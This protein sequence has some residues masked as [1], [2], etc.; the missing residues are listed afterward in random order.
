M[1]L[2]WFTIPALAYLLLQCWQEIV[3]LK[4]RH[5]PRILSEELPP[6]SIWIAARNEETNIANCLQSLVNLDY[7][8]DRMQILVGNDESKDSTREI[9]KSFEEEYN[10]ITVVDIEPDFS[11]SKA[12]VMAKLDKLA[13]GDYYLITDAD[14]CVNPN[15][16][17]HLIASMGNETGVC[18]GTTM[19]KGKGW[20]YKMQEIDWT[21]FMGLL[22]VIS[23]SG[24][25]ATAVGNNMIVRA[26]AYWETGGYSAIRFS[27]TED[28]KLYSEICKRG[29]KWNNIMHPDS[30]ATSLPVKGFLNLLHQRKRWLSGGKELPW[31]WWMMFVIFAAYYITIPFYL[32]V[33]PLPAMIVIL[34]KFLLQTAQL[35]GIYRYL[36]QPKPGIIELLLYE[37]YLSFIT[38]FTAIFFLIPVKVVW[39]GRKY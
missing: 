17:K 19:V 20:G 8:K 6:I 37:F 5:K 24:V 4:Y 28:Y 29:W 14:V 13:I 35:S 34:S 36:G 38:V 11:G 30:L 32:W 2:E 12:R 27:I 9:A 26:S 18:S 10:F 25:P 16:A 3:I 21:Y 39:K 7:P 22:N 33:Q 23:W 31:Y 15:W 1:L